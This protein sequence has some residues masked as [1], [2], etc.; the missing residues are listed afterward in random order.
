M[1]MLCC[2]LRKYSLLLPPL[3]FLDT[4]GESIPDNW[5]CA[6]SRIKMKMC[7]KCI[8]IDRS[9][10]QHESLLV[11]LVVESSALCVELQDHVVNV[12]GGAPVQPGS[13]AESDLRSFIETPSSADESTDG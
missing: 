13:R 3:I 10:L 7:K 8:K 12:D 6:Y 5:R 9:C 4:D 2:Q 11:G 1:A